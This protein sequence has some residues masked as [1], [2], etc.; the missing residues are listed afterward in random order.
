MNQWHI[1]K[2]MAGWY[3]IVISIV[4]IV[5]GGQNM[6]RIYIDLI[7][8]HVFHKVSLLSMEMLCGRISRKTGTLEAGFSQYLENRKCNIFFWKYIFYQHVFKRSSCSYVNRMWIC[9]CLPIVALRR[10]IDPRVKSTDRPDYRKMI[11]S[12]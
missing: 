11:H 5:N 1:L 10:V 2:K 9:V 6:Y 7:C 12:H 3:F 8:M 4:N